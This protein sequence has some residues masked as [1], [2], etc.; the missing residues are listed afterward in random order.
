MKTNK[1]SKYN[2]S[3][4]VANM[5]APIDREE[6]CYPAIIPDYDRTPRAGRA[7][8]I[9][10]KATPE[11]FR[12][13]VHDVLKYV[14]DKQNGH[15]IVVLKSWNEWGEGNYMEPDLKYGHGFLNALKAEMFDKKDNRNVIL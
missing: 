15:K 6:Y 12:R 4:V 8:V 1:L 7:A 3:K 2:Y 5:S 10:D 14:K 11:A 9:Y 13:H